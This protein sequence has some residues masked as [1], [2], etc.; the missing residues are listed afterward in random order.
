MATAFDKLRIHVML[1]DAD[2]FKTAAQSFAYTNWLKEKAADIDSEGKP[3]LTGLSKSPETL[4]MY[5]M[6]LGISSDTLMLYIY[7][8]EN[9]YMEYRYWVQ[10]FGQML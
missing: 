2:L 4:I 9:K 8:P 3:L 7:G 10:E 1:L 6:E 5:L